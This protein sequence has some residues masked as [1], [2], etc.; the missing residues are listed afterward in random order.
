MVGIRSSNPA[1]IEYHGQPGVTSSCV[2][3]VRRLIQFGDQ[4]TR[5]QILTHNGAHCLL[6]TINEVDLIAIKSGFGSGYAGEGARGLS[7]TL[8]LLLQHG[9]EIDEHYVDREILDRVDQALLRSSDIEELKPPSRPMRW[10]DYILDSDQRDSNARNLWRDFPPIIPF[11]SVDHRLVDLALTFW[12][13]PDAKLLTAYRRLEETLR[14]RTAIEQIGE[15]LFSRA[16]LGEEPLLIWENI[17]DNEKQ[18]RASLF[19]GAFK[20]YRNTRAHR[21]K[22]NTPTELLAEFNLLNHL[23]HLEKSAVLRRLE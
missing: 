21:T 2:A 15:K 14:T 19:T 4:V 12:E 18:G 23:F 3:A 10:Y 7:N 13:D 9:S 17:S 1:G 6:L 11:F 22:Q 8:A 20:V 16:F 5:T